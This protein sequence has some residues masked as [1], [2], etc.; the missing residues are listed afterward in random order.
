MSTDDDNIDSDGN[1]II[2]PD[3]SVSPELQEEE[4]GQPEN[5]KYI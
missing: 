1:E 5:E 2:S 3:G 4:E